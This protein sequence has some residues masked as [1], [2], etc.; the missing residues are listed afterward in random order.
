MSSKFKKHIRS[1]HRCWLGIGGVGLFNSYEEW[2]NKR[3]G[4]QITM[5]Y[6]I[7]RPTVTVDCEQLLL[8]SEDVLYPGSDKDESIEE[9]QGRRRRIELQAQHYLQGGELF[10][11]SAHLR[12][13]FADGW[14]N[15]WARKRKRSERQYGAGRAHGRI[16]RRETSTQEGREVSI[17]ETT[18]PS[19]TWLDTHNA[20]S[21]EAGGESSSSPALTPVMKLPKKTLPAMAKLNSPSNDKVLDDECL[22]C[23]GPSA[24]SKLPLSTGRSQA[25][26]T[27]SNHLVTGHDSTAKV[28]AV[29]L[30]E[31]LQ[32]SLKVVPPSSILP[33][34][35]YRPMIRN[36]RVNESEF[37]KAQAIA[38]AQERMFRELSFRSTAD[39]EHLKS[40]SQNEEPPT[41]GLQDSTKKRRRINKSDVFSGQDDKS[42]T[43]SNFSPA[44]LNGFPSVEADDQPRAER[45]QSSPPKPRQSDEV[46]VPRKKDEKSPLSS[47]VPPILSHETL[48]LETDHQP[49]AQVVPPNPVIS[50]SGLSTSI[51]S[52]ETERETIVYPVTGDSTQAAIQKAMRSFQEEGFTPLKNSTNHTHNQGSNP[53]KSPIIS[54]AFQ[55]KATPEKGFLSRPIK[56][57]IELNNVHEELMSTQAMIDAASPFTISDHTKSSPISPTKSKPSLS[58]LNSLNMSSSG[59][60]LTNEYRHDGQQRPQVQPPSFEESG[61]DLDGAISEALYFLRA[62]QVDDDISKDSSP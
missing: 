38:K 35:E 8:A 2:C 12:G 44:A 11:L 29:R 33:A 5:T 20:V 49:A 34:F 21:S 53:N 4:F 43:A 13:P 39:M 3:I 37:G 30:S 22:H 1:S 54:R 41:R 17:P 19:R 18:R 57:P 16:D 7:K 61:F 36:D 27:G 45:S 48:S 60:N 14:I 50:D 59:G 6:N 56:R 10:V 40:T 9:Q 28:A 24:A 46:N 32:G 58:T 15:P 42:T 52:L 47:T 55:A 51:N 26:A 31:A 23:T 62:S 25:T